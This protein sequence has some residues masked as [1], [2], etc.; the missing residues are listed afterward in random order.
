M[1]NTQQNK[2]I[3]QYN[4]CICMV[5]LAGAHDFKQQIIRFIR[6]L[7]SF[8]SWIVCKSVWLRTFYQFY[9]IYILM[10]LRHSR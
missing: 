6:L 3:I 9:Q 2:F 5:I 1:R 10:S 4:C 7:L 8:Y